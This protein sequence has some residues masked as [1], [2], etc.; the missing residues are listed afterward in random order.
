MLL[1]PTRRKLVANLPYDRLLTETDGPFVMVGD[2]QVIP[3]DVETTVAELA[4]VRGVS[5]NEMASRLLEN[6]R[7]LV[8]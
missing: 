2:R 5:P 6:L 1:R 7:K 4:A 3:A 8:S